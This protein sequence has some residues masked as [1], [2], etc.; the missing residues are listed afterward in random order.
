M[1]AKANSPHR[2]RQKKRLNAADR[3]ASAGNEAVSGGE[4]TTDDGAPHAKQAAKARRLFPESVPPAMVAEVFEVAGAD[5]DVV[6]SSVPPPPELPARRSSRPW[7]KPP[8]PHP[9][10]PNRPSMAPA[11]VE[12]VDALELP[13]DELED[14]LPARPSRSSSGRGLWLAIGGLALLL[15]VAVGVRACAARASDASAEPSHAVAR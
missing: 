6:L 7:S 5:D 12:E 3:A 14:E 1:G 2:K 13:S 8:V 10:H 9:P 11:P 4:L 15:G